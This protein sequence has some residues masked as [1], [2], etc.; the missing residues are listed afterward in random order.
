MYIDVGIEATAC[1]HS[2]N[3]N[4]IQ[5]DA[6]EYGTAV[7]SF[8]F[9]FRVTYMNLIAHSVYVAETNAVNRCFVWLGSWHF[10]ELPL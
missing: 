3:T 7:C 6:I 4:T 10:G 5:Y 8:L 2:A 9:R 1:A